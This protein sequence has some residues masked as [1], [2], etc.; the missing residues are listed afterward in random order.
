MAVCC[1]CVRQAIS[2]LSKLI[3][4]EPANERNFYKVTHISSARVSCVRCTYSMLIMK[5]LLLL[6]NS[7]TART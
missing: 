2:L 5:W 1:L 4:L 3:E 6:V 7:A